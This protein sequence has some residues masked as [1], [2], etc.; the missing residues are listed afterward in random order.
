MAPNIQTRQRPHLRESGGSNRPSFEAR[1]STP[2]FFPQRSELRAALQA[3]AGAKK[4]P[5]ALGVQDFQGPVPAD[6]EQG[7]LEDLV[8]RMQRP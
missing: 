7:Q 6:T 1:R 4:R 5:L 2:G 8:D 3:F